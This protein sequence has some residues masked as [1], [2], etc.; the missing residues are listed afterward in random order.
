VRAKEETIWF[1][2]VTMIL[3][4]AICTQVAASAPAA[5]RQTARAALDKA[6]AKAKA[7]HADAV[8]IEVTTD[9]DDKGTADN[10]A[11]MPSLGWAYVFR[12]ASAKKRLQINASADGLSAADSDLGPFDDP[13]NPTY[14]KPISA[15]FVDSDR[16]I[17]EARSNGLAGKTK[18]YS[19]DLSDMHREGMIE[20]LCWTI[21]DD[22]G[23]FF[24]VSATSGKV[25]SKVSLGH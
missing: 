18:K 15:T 17:A 8:L 22:S 16:A 5:N 10:N 25:L 19:V 12:S 1:M 24:T 2:S 7:W 4:T 20:T 21:A 9:V 3:A 14:V 13:H 6:Q 23:S 11:D